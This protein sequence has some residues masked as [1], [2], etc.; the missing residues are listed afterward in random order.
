MS[1]RAL[2][3]VGG[4]HR[5]CADDGQSYLRFKQKER[6]LNKSQVYKLNMH[7]KRNDRG[8]ISFCSTANTVSLSPS[9]CFYCCFV[10]DYFSVRH[11][12]LAVL[13]IH[14]C[15]HLTDSLPSDFR[16]L[17]WKPIVSKH[18]H[19]TSSTLKTKVNENLI[20]QKWCRRRRTLT[21]LPNKNDKEKNKPGDMKMLLFKFIGLLALLL[22]NQKPGLFWTSFNFC[23][24]PPAHTCATTKR[25]IRT[26]ENVFF[27]HAKCMEI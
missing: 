7:I 27:F 8:I 14:C 5:Q 21:P 4:W 20:T 17:R 6:S 10:L 24:A 12:F 15:R 22:H 19:Q 3:I 18:R 25:R 13:C 16:S 11:W 26:A 2:Y 9:V 23:R 1:F